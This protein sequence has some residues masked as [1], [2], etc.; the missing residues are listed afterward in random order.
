MILTNRQTDYNAFSTVRKSSFL[1][2]VH[3]IGSC[4]NLETWLDLEHRQMHRCSSYKYVAS[5]SQ[6]S[7]RP[8][9]ESRVRHSRTTTNNTRLCVI[10]NARRDTLCSKIPSSTRKIEERNSS[11]R[12]LA[13]GGVRS[14]GSTDR[15]KIKSANDFSWLP[16]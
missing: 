12:S 4:L 5:L 3:T 8:R 2:L 7:L 15:C 1:S 10:I 11:I 16:A 9:I 6:D 14:R 13:A